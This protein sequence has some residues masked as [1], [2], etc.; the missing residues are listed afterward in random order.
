MRGS[1]H[2]ILTAVNDVG[3]EADEQS[4]FK[5]LNKCHTTHKRNSHDLNLGISA[6]P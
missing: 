6:Q 3:A 4:A 2:L 1:S 5:K